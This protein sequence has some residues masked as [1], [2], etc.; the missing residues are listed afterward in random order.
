MGG[1]SILLG[2]YYGKS[3]KSI[4]MGEGCM[5]RL[6]N[7]LLPVATLLNRQKHIAALRMGMM[8]TVPLTIV[9]AMFLVLA[10]PPVSETMVGG[11]NF[12]V[13]FLLVW[14]EWALTYQ[15]V[16]LVP[17]Q[18][19]IGILSIY[20]VFAIAYF[21]AQRYE[22]NPIIN[23]FQGLLTFLTIA[24]MPITVENT[25]MLPTT[26]LDA[27]GMFTAIIVGL[28]T[29]EVTRLLDQWGLKI[30]MPDSV[31]PMVAAPFEILIPLFTNILLFLG[32]NQGIIA[33]TGSGMVILVQKLLGPLLSVSGSLGSILL[34]NFLATTF[35]F[36]GIHGTSILNTV[37]IPIAT[38]NFAENAV[39]YQLGEAIPHV[40]AGSYNNFYGSWITYPALLCC[41]LFFVRS[42][43]LK[44][45]ARAALIPNLFNINEPLIFGLPI[46]MNV[47][48]I[49]PIYLCN[50]LNIV[51]SYWL[52]NS[53][54]VGKFIVNVPWTTPGP[55][56]VFLSTLDWKASLL[57]FALFGVDLLICLP[58]AKSYDQ[59]VR[60]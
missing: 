2:I 45:L 8:I 60:L 20:T 46:V 38:A 9:G 5:T 53:G 28:L 16:L 57:W 36:F 40:F 35:W 48:L 52:M 23:G 58:F 22:L 17:Y 59:Q 30:R 29:V 1:F 47:I 15:T 7:V 31:P 14:K 50:A 41:F 27:K 13:D 43:Q 54:I 12:F 55:V 44:S 26:F 51:V 56:A 10:Q 39:A 11:T 3:R 32:I 49:I 24:V 6:T 33:L 21:L 25:T 18:L 34:I 19:T 42:I 4:Q 37:V